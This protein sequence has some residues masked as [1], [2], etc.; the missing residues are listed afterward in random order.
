MVER[1]VEDVQVTNAGHP[2]WPVVLHSTFT[3]D[4]CGETWRCSIH[5]H[6]ACK[7]EGVGTV[8][9]SLVLFP[10]LSLVLFPFP[11]L[12]LLCSPVGFFLYCH[13]ILSFVLLIMFCGSKL[14]ETVPL[15]ESFDVPV[16][17]TDPRL[18]FADGLHTGFPQPRYA[19]FHNEDVWEPQVFS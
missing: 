11:S 4:E 14:I 3:A 1:E 7:R 16:P 19:R 13:S 5:F 10:F 6:A 17:C 8:V 9:P 15:S 2:H 12:P 18:F